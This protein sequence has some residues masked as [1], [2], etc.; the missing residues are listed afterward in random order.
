MRIFISY[1][2]KDADWADR[3]ETLLKPLARDRTVQLW[4]DD[5][6][7]PGV[8]WRA[9][10][11]RGLAEADAG[12][13]LVSPNFLASDFVM[14]TELPRLL[15]RHA[16]GNLQLFGVL[17]DDCLLETTPLG[18][19]QFAHPHDKPLADLD[20]DARDDAMLAIVRAIHRASQDAAHAGGLTVD[21]GDLPSATGPFVGRAQELADLDAALADAA[22]R[23][24][25]LEAWGGVGKSALVQAWLSRLVRD[26]Y[27]GL[28]RVYAYS[29]YRQGV[30]DGASSDDFFD[31]AFAFFGEPRPKYADAR[32]RRL[33]ALTLAGR[34]LLILDGLEPLQAAQDGA[35]QDPAMRALLVALADGRP[36][37]GLCLVTTRRRVPALDARVDATVRRFALGDL[38]EDDGVAL[39]REHKA[40]GS[41]ADLRRAVRVAK[42]H[43]L[44]LT[45][46]GRFVAR[47]LQRDIRRAAEVDLLRPDADGVP[48]A[49]RMLDR[50]VEDLADRPA[51]DVLRL[52][53]LFDRPAAADC[54][55][56]LR[57]APAIP[58][59]TDR[60]VDLDEGDWQEALT[61]LRDLGLLLAEDRAR[62]GRLD[63]HP[64]VRAYAADHLDPAAAR[65]GHGWLY[66][67]L[68]ATSSHRP[69]TVAE[70][71]R[72][73]QAVMHGCRA[74]RAP[75]AFADV[76]LARIL[77]G[78]D[79]YAVN[80]LG[81]F[82]TELTALAAF[83][84]VPFT[85]PHETLIPVHQAFVL[86]QA[87]FALRT[88]GR[89][90]QAR[91]SLR[92]SLARFEALEEWH[93][94]AR[95][96]IN[97]SDVSVAQGALASAHDET[98][99]AVALAERIGDVP[100]QVSHRAA[101]ASVHHQRGNR[102]AA[103]AGFEAAEALQVEAPREDGKRVYPFLYAVQGYHYC[104]LL[105]EDGSPPAARAVLAR[106]AQTR[107]WVALPGW[108]LEIA[109][110]DVSLGRA[111]TILAW[112]GGSSESAAQARTH[113]DAA[114]DGLHAAEASDHLPH[115]W[116]A[117][118]AYH[119]LIDR[120]VAAAEADLRAIDDLV[121]FSGMRLFACDAHLERARLLRD[122]SPAD[123]T[124]EQARPH[125]DAA[126]SLIVE[127]GYH[128]R[129]GELANL[130]R[131][132]SGEAIPKDVLGAWG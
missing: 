131:W 78:N 69:D 29:F 40:D 3:F 12:L 17:L 85:R 7:R 82:G 127:T 11:E 95:T 126:K 21:T 104:A 10:I 58:G 28:S 72:L 130:E 84:D 86:G 13:L 83:F 92:A 50:T 20:D 55:A 120:D 96:A 60:L 63:T 56:A 38:N 22:I 42:G 53:G 71:A 105:L 106:A 46:F 118:A 57:Q 76:Y 4:R 94:A 26:D 15:E 70:M 30:E 47:R 23:I 18:A 16:R 75:E 125:V 39:L 5:R 102:S 32:G 123:D 107:A 129:D 33:A 98:A 103:A 19:L 117:R 48:R 101:Q 14:E 124:R 36:G 41:D 67:H 99:R 100:A 25:T 77:R 113:L 109:L 108:T 122:L 9:E 8:D 1:S 114:V 89:L 88:L 112:A 52:F 74:D 34:A 81:M 61:E 64:L 27:R 79:H 128:R 132:L 80:Q 54:V 59:L 66:A 115:A 24:A 116:L 2:R 121:T 31:R 91:A 90:T 6:M 110:D 65:A 45:L 111:H 49:R 62:P 37:P 43:A 35:L 73:Y 44:T 119:R 68:T 93:Q 51:G 87:G 97:L